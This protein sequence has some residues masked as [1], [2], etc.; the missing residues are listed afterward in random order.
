MNVIAD[1]LSRSKPFSTEWQINPDLFKQI[2]D[3]LPTLSVDLFETC[4]NAQLPVPLTPFPDK[5]T[6]RVDALSHS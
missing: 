1:S 5:S 4:R 6:K 2:F 3:L